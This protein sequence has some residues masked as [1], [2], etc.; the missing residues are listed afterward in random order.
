MLYIQD[1]IYKEY[2]NMMM[3]I[4]IL[5][6][7]LCISLS[8][9]II[10]ITASTYYGTLRPISPWR[11]LVSVITPI[12]IVSN[13]LKKKSL[14]NSGALAGMFWS[15]DFAEIWCAYPVYLC[16]C[17]GTN[18]GI[19]FIGLVSSFLGGLFVGLAY[20]ITQLLFVSDLEISAPQWPIILYGGAAGFLG[21]MIDSYLGAL[22]QYSGYD[23]TTGKIVNHPTSEAKLISGK[24]ILDN[25]TVNL[26]SSVLIALLLPGVA[27][28]FWP[29][30]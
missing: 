27:W 9:W 23:E 5:S 11:W 8:F 30:T 1:E 22:M 28:S 13:G 4:F 7:I 24:P 14:D 12:I 21:S 20:F 2:L 18:G 25:N 3:N 29:R 17:L 26:F 10:S 19:T 15:L 6:I 16:F